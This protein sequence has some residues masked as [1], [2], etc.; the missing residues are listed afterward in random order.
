VGREPADAAGRGE[1]FRRL[2]A[3][4]ELLGPWVAGQGRGAE[5][6]LA[7]CARGLR[8]NALL[9]RRDYAFCLYPQEK[10]RPFGTQFL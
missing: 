2:R 6:A 8:A 7:R 3:L 5:A 9:R 1:R 4:N 10:L